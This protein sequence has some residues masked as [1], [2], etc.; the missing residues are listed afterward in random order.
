MSKSL[1]GRLTALACGA[2]AM[3][4][5]CVAT[6]AVAATAVQG[7]QATG[8]QVSQVNVAAE[9]SRIMAAFPGAERLSGDTVRLPSGVEV[10]VQL[11]GGCSLK[12]LCLYSQRSLQGEQLNLTKCGFTDI[13]RLWGN[14]KTRSYINNQI[15]GTRSV[16]YN[17]LNPGW[18]Q[19]WASVAYDSNSS[20]GGYEI[21]EG[22]AVC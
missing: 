14:D 19:V 8:V 11:A 17:W 5:I 13:G 6:P 16:F 1:L 15:Q 22:V 21:A 7:S 3:L 20:G 18:G 2:A 9:T 12:Y 10:S 4:G